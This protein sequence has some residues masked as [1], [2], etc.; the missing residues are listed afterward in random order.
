MVKLTVLFGHP[1]NPEAFEAYYANY[2]LPLAAKLPHVQCFESGRVRV[3]DGGAP[4]YHRIAEVWFE[5]AARMGEA[6]SSPEGKAATV[7]LQNFATGGVTFFVSQV[8]A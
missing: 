1:D 7:D 3:A 5:N 6:M 2:H 4:P 8:E